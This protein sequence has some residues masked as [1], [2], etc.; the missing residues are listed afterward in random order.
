ML[1]DDRSL[2]RAQLRFPGGLP[3]SAGFWADTEFEKWFGLNVEGL[4]ITRRIL[5]E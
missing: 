3:R 5:L 2:R 1:T 4:T